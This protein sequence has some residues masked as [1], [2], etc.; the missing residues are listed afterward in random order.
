MVIVWHARDALSHAGRQEFAVIDALAQC[1]EVWAVAGPG[2]LKNAGTRPGVS[3]DLLSL[4]AGISEDLLRL[5]VRVGNRL[6]RSLLREFED[7][8]RGSHGVA[9]AS[10]NPSHDEPPANPRDRVARP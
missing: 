1:G 9:F 6:F 3:D 4:L 5:S 8:S 7:P 10:L 2:S